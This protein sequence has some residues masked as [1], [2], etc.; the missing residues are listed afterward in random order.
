MGKFVRI[1][2]RCT[3]KPTLRSEGPRTSRTQHSCKQQPGILSRRR[4]GRDFLSGLPKVTAAGG[5]CTSSRRR[6]STLH[7]SGST[8]PKGFA[9][10]LRLDE[11]DPRWISLSTSHCKPD[12]AQPQDH[13]HP[14]ARFRNCA[15]SLERNIVEIPP[16]GV[17]RPR[18]S[19]Y[20]FLASEG[21][22]LRYRLLSPNGRSG[23][24][25][26]IRPQEHAID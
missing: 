7:R 5:C 13:Q 24:A 15:K 20:Q 17:R 1:C 25:A 18:G 4:S 8:D 23:R 26:R 2:S 10:R 12:R 21:R 6:H 14:R 3:S 16:K 19:E 9:T 11:R 22:K